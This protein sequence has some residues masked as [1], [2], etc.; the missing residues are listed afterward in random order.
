M[1][2]RHW[3]WIAAGLVAWAGVVVLWAT[4][5]TDCHPPN[6]QGA[7]TCGCPPTDVQSTTN[8][9]ETPCTTSQP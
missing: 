1:R 6:E 8:Q 3:S 2:A 4:T 7:I 9:K 5:P